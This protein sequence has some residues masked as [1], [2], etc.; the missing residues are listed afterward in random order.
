[1]AFVE[2]IS[3]SSLDTEENVNCWPIK[4]PWNICWSLPE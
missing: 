3:S 1:V 2:N 4:V